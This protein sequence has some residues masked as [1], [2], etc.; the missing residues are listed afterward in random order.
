MRHI[1][2]ENDENTKKNPSFARWFR[3]N[4]NHDAS[5]AGDRRGIILRFNPDTGSFEPY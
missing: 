3:N 2:K 5:Q 1:R 4:S